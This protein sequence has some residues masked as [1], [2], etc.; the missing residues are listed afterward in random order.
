MALLC[1][2]YSYLNQ[3]PEKQNNN[4]NKLYSLLN[5]IFI[6]DQNYNLKYLINIVL[7]LNQN[8]DNNGY[9]KV[10]FKS[11]IIDLYF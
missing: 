3:E 6:M 1:L 10:T 8:I 4:L 5:D 11:N 9:M 2:L 7:E